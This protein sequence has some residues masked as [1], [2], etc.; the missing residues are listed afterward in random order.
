MLFMYAS[1]VQQSSGRRLE[2][3]CSSF[4]PLRVQDPTGQEMFDF[5]LA[6]LMFKGI[7]L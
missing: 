6:A 5:C 7:A 3:S 2:P 4:D 1:A